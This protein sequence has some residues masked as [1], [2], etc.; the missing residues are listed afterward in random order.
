VLASSIPAPDARIGLLLVEP[1]GASLISHPRAA[2]A[3]NGTGDLV[4]AVLAAGLAHGRTGPEAAREAAQAVAD[5][6][7]DAA[8]WKSADLIIVPTPDRPLR[9]APVR[10]E[11]MGEA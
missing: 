3:P 4:T 8:L 1:E 10:V 7:A 9:Q 5:A 6:V 2:G 11:A